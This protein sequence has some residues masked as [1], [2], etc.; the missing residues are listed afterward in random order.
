MKPRGYQYP[1]TAIVGQETMKQAL[2]L[3]AINPAIGGVLIRGEK[4]TAKSTAARAL[5][6]L[7]PQRNVVS[8]CPFN[9]NPGDPEGLCETCRQ[10]YPDLT[11]Y[12]DFMRVIEL[13]VSA[14]E[15][16]VVGSLDIGHALK[17]GEKIFEPGILAQ[18]NRNILYVDEVNLLN[19][20]V[21]DVLLDVAAMGINYV[22]REGVS[23]SHP[24][25]FILVGTMNPE[26]GELRPQLLDRFGLCVEISGLPDKEERLEIIRRR[27]AFERDPVAFC[28][29]W[30]ENEKRL[31]ER[32]GSARLLLDKVQVSDER[33]KLIVRICTEME[34]DGHRA[35][36]AMMKTAATIAAFAGRTEV[37]E[38]DIRQAAA[39]VL[40]HRMRRQPFSDRKMDEQKIDESIRRERNEGGSDG[41]ARHSHGDTPSD[42]GGQNP[43][44]T[45]S[46]IFEPGAPFA[47]DPATLGREH[48]SDGKLRQGIGRRRMTAA[49]SGR[50][51]G[52]RIPD[53]PTADIAF[54]AT[55][56]AAAPH[57]LF[58]M[59]DLAVTI[60][61][62]DIRAKVRERKMGT[63]LV[64]VVDTSG[65]MGV[66]QR[67]VAVKGAILSILADAYQKRDRV[68]L[69]GFRG[70]GAELLLSPTGSVELAQRLLR[71]LPTGGKTPLAD[72]LSLG[73]SLIERE[74]IRNKTMLP[75]LVLVS[76]GKANAGSGSAPPFKEALAA[77]D[78]IRMAGIPALVIDPEQGFLRL[79]LVGEISARMG[80]AYCHID[81]LRTESITGLIHG[82]GM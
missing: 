16:K 44:A 19:D 4:G 37:T 77:A 15:D 79:G 59:G 11:S 14:T 78:R 66:Q 24:S 38:E 81:E 22:E 9:C 32:I 13:P 2:I 56:R 76:D 25:S 61:P 5:A 60:H 49:D 73:L 29:A 70:P 64:F 6:S 1:F 23:F 27:I 75:L 55:I 57:Q 80:A 74:Q 42:T 20:H 54:D 63:T 3:N 68:G 82:I 8:G 46:A 62:S 48:R 36:I 47:L 31:C 52:S 53:A 50:Y 41:A 34:V 71:S 30:S 72:G 45:Q 12:P 40:P 17:K 10:Q 51:V 21:V 58:R 7:L 28:A 33:L 67:M 65:S 69:I 39:L 26:E 35:D 18:A 43:D